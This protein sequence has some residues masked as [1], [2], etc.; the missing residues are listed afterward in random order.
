MGR[1]GGQPEHR[2]AADDGDDD[3]AASRAPGPPPHATWHAPC[4]DREAAYGGR[5]APYEG[6]D[7]RY[8]AQDVNDAAR[9]VSDVRAPYDAYDGADSVGDASQAT[10]DAESRTR[11]D[12]GRVGRRARARRVA[13]RRRR[14]TL[15]EI[16][17]L[18][19]AA[20][21]IA[22][23]LKTFFVQAF[24]IPSGSMEETLRIGDRVVVDKLTPW[25]GADVHRGDVVVFRDPGGWLGAEE[26]DQ[27]TSSGPVRQLKKGLA[28]IGLLPSA[29]EKDLIK[30]VVGVGGDTV[31]C[32][33]ARGRVTVNGQAVEE[34]YVRAGNRPSEVEFR[35][36]VPAGR[37]FVLG[38]HRADSG[39][40]RFH[41]DAG[42][43]GTVAE[44]AVVGRAVAVVWPVGHWSTPGHRERFARVPDAASGWPVRTDDSH[45]LAQARPKAGVALPTPAELPLVMGVVG[46]RLL[47]RG[48]GLEVRSERGG[49]R[50]GR[51]VRTRGAGRAGA[52]RRGSGRRRGRAGA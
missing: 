19:G 9:S 42:F 40:S 49:R 11:R 33:D 20:L 47:R 6:R 12:V 13:R 41:S 25:F 31:A 32:C 24:V 22:L 1:H 8:D 45:S 44:D 35:V 48:Q 23:V 5:E 50:G 4:E 52:G 15:R 10:Y 2:G 14:A 26:Q 46:P 51:P 21:L 16:P 28:F 37:L 7:A 38:D 39:D 18:L 27:D 29:D 17:L 36:R 34:P 30:R 43:D 3:D